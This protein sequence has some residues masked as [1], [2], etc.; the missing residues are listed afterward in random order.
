VKAHFGFWRGTLARS[1]PVLGRN[2]EPL[3]FDPETLVRMAGEGVERGPDGRLIAEDIGGLDG[4]DL[5]GRSSLGEG[6]SSVGKAQNFS[7]VLTK[8]QSELDPA[9]QG[10]D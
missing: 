1:V 9:I 3:F 7:D 10:S 6:H 2:D 8:T 4:V 5:R